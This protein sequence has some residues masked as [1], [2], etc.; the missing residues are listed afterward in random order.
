MRPLPS[1]LKPP[2]KDTSK[3]QARDSHSA[4]PT[5]DELT[6]KEPSLQETTGKYS[7]Q[8]KCNRD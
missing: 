3:A 4:T 1:P 6:V 7:Q 2:W 8:G 5:E